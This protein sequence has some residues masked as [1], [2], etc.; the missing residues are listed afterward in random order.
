MGYKI[1]S[2]EIRNFKYIADEKPLKFDFLNSDLI[3]FNGQ[4]G[5]GKTT[6]F[7]SLELLFTGRVARL[8]TVTNR[9]TT[10]NNLNEL[11]HDVEKDIVVSAV[12]ANDEK[13]INIVR[14]FD[15]SKSFISTV[16]MDD[17]EVQQEKIYELLHISESMYG[18]GIYL[19][20][21][22][23]LTFLEQRY[24]DRRSMV[25]ELVNLKKIED[26]IGRVNLIT[27]GIKSRIADKK[28]EYEKK[29]AAIGNEIEQIKINI[30]SLSKEYSG[31]IKYKKLFEKK[32]LFD[33]MSIDITKP[34]SIMVEPLVH[35]KDYLRDYEKLEIYENN[36]KV[37]QTIALPKEYY[38][39]EYYK[40]IVNDCLENVDLRKLVLKCTQYRESIS[41]DNYYVDQEVLNS[42]G[43][44]AES[45][46]EIESKIETLK[47]LRFNLSETERIISGINK[48]RKELIERY[49]TGVRIS[50]IPHD[51]CPLCGSDIESIDLCFKKTE[52]S[53]ISSV[54]QRNLIEEQLKADLRVTFEKSVLPPL[55]KFI[56]SHFQLYQNGNLLASCMNLDTTNL[57]KTLKDLKISFE[58]TDSEKVDLANFEKDY[59]IVIASLNE[60]VRPLDTCFTPETIQLYEN[61]KTEVYSNQKPTH[62]ISDI[63]SKIMYVAQK[64]NSEAQ[65]KLSNL[66]NEKKLLEENQIKFSDESNKV[67]NDFETLLR[68]YKETFSSFQTKLANSIRIPVVIYSGKIIQNYP[69]GLGVNTKVSKSQLVFESFEK[70]GLD[71]FNI[72]STGQLNGL[73]ISIL[74]SIRDVYGN[75]DG[76]DVL[77]ID[78]P[79]QTIDEISSISL[80]D[81]LS[82]G[83]ISQMLLSTHEDRKARM[84]TYKFKKL[85]YKTTA[86]NMKN[87]YLKYT[88]VEE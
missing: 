28:T 1:R 53:L 22:K 58:Q 10:P 60:S 11:A 71:A 46:T 68:K 75:K 27:D 7:D 56:E 4:N 14:I 44:D 59:K 72:F 48:A 65:R 80:A 88:R 42:I 40:K 43:V 2:L 25:A 51:K 29:I 36:Q 57:M 34:Y 15:H 45:Q 73:A 32:Y 86:L 26:E 84:L 24:K 54:G 64:Y 66:E 79:L 39:K 18:M 70:P 35:I 37:L 78:D 61:I 21:S 85:N 41:A 81:L 69:M 6:V 52:E 30:S 50:L 83:D 19:S 82:S 20:Q 76:L 55:N 16:L 5:Y 38:I 87:T 12:I 31:E 67:L 9:Q 49:A 17:E 63:E 47:M 3:I 62:T 8:C 77:L 13:Q 74:L 23:S 33:E